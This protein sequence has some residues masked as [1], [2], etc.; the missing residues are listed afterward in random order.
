MQRLIISG[1]S[2]LVVLTGLSIPAQAN[3]QPQRLQARGNDDYACSY[4]YR[5]GDD[6]WV[7]DRESSSTRFQ[8]KD[9]VKN[10]LQI[11]ESEA[12]DSSKNFESDRLFCHYTLGS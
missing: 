11:K 10:I 7:Y 1:L 5:V 12:N 8:A 6:D 4:R 9:A 2:A 3:L